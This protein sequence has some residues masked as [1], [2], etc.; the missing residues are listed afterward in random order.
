MA[1]KK[2]KTKRSTS[3]QKSKRQTR[4]QVRKQ[5]SKRQ[6]RRQ[7]RKQKSKPQSPGQKRVYHR[8]P[9]PKRHSRRLFYKP[10]PMRKSRRLNHRS[11]TSHA[12]NLFRMPKI[13]PQF[14]RG[15]QPLNKKVF[16]NY[17]GQKGGT[18]DLVLNDPLVREEAGRRSDILYP[19][20]TEEQRSEA[21]MAA[22]F[23]IFLQGSI[24]D[25]VNSFL[26][27]VYNIDMA[28]ELHQMTRD[29]ALA[30]ARYHI[31][32][33]IEN[34]QKVYDMATGEGRRKLIDAALLS[35]AEAA[36][37]GKVIFL[38]PPFQ[39][40]TEQLSPERLRAVITHIDNQAA[41]LDNYRAAQPLFDAFKGRVRYEFELN[42][43]L[44][45]GA[46]QGVGA[47]FNDP[48]QGLRDRAAI[49]T[50]NAWK[51]MTSGIQPITDELRTLLISLRD[52]V[53][54]P[55]QPND[56]STQPSEDL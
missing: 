42:D 28:R 55:Q 35:A 12:P 48:I 10:M 52:S 5:K 53:P 29:E 45:V 2:K 33:H 38:G 37:N 15:F 18:Q 21:M 25:R 39:E 27:T 41:V 43:R 26:K 34:A 54:L 4:R 40:A 56:I 9:V 8:M 47:D 11:K 30:D 20:L 14:S 7:V 50:Q 3:K 6:T 31:M 16:K 1:S 23:G 13:Y 17:F 49:A 32:P 44:A 51:E 36:F 22:T 24:D 19:T 46:L